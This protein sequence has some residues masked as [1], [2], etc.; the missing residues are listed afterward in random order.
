MQVQSLHSQTLQTNFVSELRENHC[1]QPQ[2]GKYSKCGCKVNAE[3]NL[4]ISTWEML[5][6]EVSAWNKLGKLGG[7]QPTA[8]FCRTNVGRPKGKTSKYP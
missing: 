8:C 4:Q 2:Q 3:K 7:G 6:P 1:K 5:L